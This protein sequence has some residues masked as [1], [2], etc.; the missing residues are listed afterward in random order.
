MEWR[1][2]AALWCSCTV[3]PRIPNSRLTIEAPISPGIRF[4]LFSLNQQYSTPLETMDDN[5][6]DILAEFDKRSVPSST[7]DLSDLTK[8]WIAERGAPE[9]LPYQGPLLERIM[10]RIREQV[11]YARRRG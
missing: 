9:I 2:T 8:Q 11:L 7:Q 6:D 5:I 10:E 1:I 3:D 4:S